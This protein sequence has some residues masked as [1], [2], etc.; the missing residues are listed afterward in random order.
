MIIEIF[1]ILLWVTAILLVVSGIDDFYLD[2]MY[3]L[4]RGKYKRNLPDFT[5]MKRKPERPIS[6]MI[7]AWQ[8]HKVIGRTLKN[9]LRKQSIKVAM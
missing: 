5:E 7:G 4:R 1:Q 8:E 9:A 6:V 3:W 2:L